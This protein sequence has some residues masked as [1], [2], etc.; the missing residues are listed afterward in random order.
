MNQFTRF[1][2]SLSTLDPNIRWIPMLV[3][4]ACFGVSCSS[5]PSSSSSEP[6]FS[7]PEDLSARRIG[8]RQVLALAEGV[9]LHADKITA[10][11]DG[12]VEASGSVYADGHAAAAP[13]DGFGWPQH[14]YSESAVWNSSER[15]LLLT[16]SPIL[17]FPHLR[18]TSKTSDCV[19]TVDGCS[20]RT[21]GPTVTEITRDPAS[22]KE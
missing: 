10:L 20:L 21:V 5:A 8:G 12:H 22:K 7:P 17:E 9:K 6:W 1:D 3:V 2:C 4:L 13:A 16:G 18:I 11:P 15:R 14:A 19:M